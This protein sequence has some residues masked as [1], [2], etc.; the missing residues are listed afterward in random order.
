M[1]ISRTGKDLCLKI[2]NN[3][4]FSSFSHMFS[5]SITPVSHWLLADFALLEVKWLNTKKYKCWWP[6]PIFKS[7]PADEKAEKMYKEKRSIYSIKYIMP[8]IIQIPKTNYW[9]C[10]LFT[11]RT[12]FYWSCAASLFINTNYLS[13]YHACSV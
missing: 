13:L 11:C 5:Y 12:P 10:Q 3:V 6:Y 2:I 8:S 9:T 1:Y 4:F 7:M